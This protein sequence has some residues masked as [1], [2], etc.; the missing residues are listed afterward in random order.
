MW[1]VQ[2]FS[3][4][5]ASFPEFIDFS[6]HAKF[7]AY[8]G[9]SVL[10][11]DRQLNRIVT[12]ISFNIAGLSNKNGKNANIISKVLATVSRPTFCFTNRFLIKHFHQFASTGGVTYLRLCVV[13]WP[14]FVNNKYNNTLV[15][16]SQIYY[17]QGVHKVPSLLLNFWTNN[18]K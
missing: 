8:P 18:N 1:K 5:K 7:P 16:R 3:S 14:G 11:V 10:Q 15:I 17:T 9:I 12:S 4:S 6:R 13:V 2:L